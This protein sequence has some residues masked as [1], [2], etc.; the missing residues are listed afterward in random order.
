V[1]KANV[2]ALDPPS[3]PTLTP[4]PSSSAASGGGGFL[5]LLREFDGQGGSSALSQGREELEATYMQPRGIQRE[6]EASEARVE[7]CEPRA[8]KRPPPLHAV[9]RGVRGVS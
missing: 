3:P 5:P 4:T 9:V 2:A 8:R 6:G 7:V 1:R